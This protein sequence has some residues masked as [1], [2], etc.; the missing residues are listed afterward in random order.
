MS[1]AHKLTTEQLSAL[2]A[3]LVCCAAL[4]PQWKA[5]LLKGTETP[6]SSIALSS[7]CK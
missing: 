7:L 3:P 1:G 5:A 4:R 2:C 6:F